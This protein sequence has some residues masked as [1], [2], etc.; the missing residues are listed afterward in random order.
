M[1]SCSCIYARQS[2]GEEL[3]LF[4][5]KHPLPFFWLMLLSEEDVEVYRSKMLQLS[6]QDVNPNT[7]MS[8]DKLKAISRA[9]NRRD[10]IKQYYHITCLPLFD[11]WLYF[12]Q[13]SDFSDMKI[14]V[15]L[16]ET[17]TSYNDLNHFC[18]S[19]LKAI[20]CFDENKE[21]W[22]E[23]TVAGACG[24]EGNSN[25]KKSFGAMSKAYRKLKKDSYKRFDK[26]L[27]LDK[28]MTAGKKKMLLAVI[29]LLVILLIIAILA[30]WI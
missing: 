15:D 24:Y 5:G 4:E 20:A 26:K 7:S 11:D 13:I 6:P 16:Y 25:H 22:Y 3:I 10:Y 14:Y 12:L 29:L 30:V 18:D 1:R 28:K 19:M 9:A 17:G 27:H 8:L 23:E 21:A 2:D